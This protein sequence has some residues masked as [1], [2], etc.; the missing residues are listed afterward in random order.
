MNYIVL[1]VPCI[2]FVM[3]ELKPPV[4]YFFNIPTFRRRME[5]KT[6]KGNCLKVSNYKFFTEQSNRL[7]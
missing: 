7:N 3:K 4:Q 1:M 5:I 6:A 2:V